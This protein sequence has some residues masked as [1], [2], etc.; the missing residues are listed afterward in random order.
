MDCQRFAPR[1][2]WR[3]L[4]VV[5]AAIA[6]VVFGHLRDIVTDVEHWP[7][8]PYPMYSYPPPDRLDVYRVVGVPAG[9]ATGGSAGGSAREFPLVERRYLR[10]LDAGS[11]GA[12]MSRLNRRDARERLLDEA[13]RACLARYEALR[14]AGRHDGPPLRGARLYRLSWPA[15][16][17][18]PRDTP[19]RRDLLYEV[20]LDEAR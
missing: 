5:H 3:R 17:T 2:S 8:S 9:A 11:L 13:L 4:L 16:V 20:T 6:V 12:T 10:P 1:M 7:F 15:D 18:G 14:A 19:D